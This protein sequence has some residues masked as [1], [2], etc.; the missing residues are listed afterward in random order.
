MKMQKEQQKNYLRK[1]KITEDDIFD[2]ALKNDSTISE[3]DREIVEKLKSNNYDFR[4]T[5]NDS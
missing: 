5:L 2:I 4:K 1:K 3:E